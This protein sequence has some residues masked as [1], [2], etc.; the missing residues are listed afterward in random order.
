MVATAVAE[1]E[2]SIWRVVDWHMER[3]MKLWIYIHMLPPTHPLAALRIPKGHRFV[4]LLQKI[5]QHEEPA[6]HME[7]IKAYMMPPWEE[8]CKG[9]AVD[10]PHDL[11]KAC[12]TT[13]TCA[14]CT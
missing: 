5:A 8:H 7:K 13:L 14:P 9:K 6:S 3:A 1:A 2:A 12:G 11:L 10:R 4:S